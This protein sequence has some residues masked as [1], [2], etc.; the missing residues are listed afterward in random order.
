MNVDNLY[1]GIIQCMNL[2]AFRINGNAYHHRVQAITADRFCIATDIIEHN[3]RSFVKIWRSPDHNQCFLSRGWSFYNQE[4]NEYNLFEIRYH[5]TTRTYQYIVHTIDTLNGVLKFRM[6]VNLF[7]PRIEYHV[8]GNNVINTPE[9]IRWELFKMSKYLCRIDL[10]IDDFQIL[11][12][13]VNIPLNIDRAIKRKMQLMC[14][15]K[16]DIELDQL[17]NALNVAGYP[18]FAEIAHNF[19]IAFRDR[20]KILFHD[21][22]SVIVAQL[23]DMEL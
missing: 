18:Q 2:G 4:G 20:A 14:S 15:V 23:D 8:I 16:I 6:Q 7:H 9:N 22:N 13:G 19:G 21:P 3:L 12:D 10:S 17:V 5:I 11:N 1:D